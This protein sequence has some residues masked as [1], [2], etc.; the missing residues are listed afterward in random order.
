MAAITLRRLATAPARSRCASFF[1]VRTTS[2]HTSDETCAPTSLQRFEGNLSWGRACDDSVADWKCTGFLSGRGP[3]GNECVWTAVGTTGACGG[4]ILSRSFAAK[5]KKPKSKTED[6]VEVE[7]VSAAAKESAL[8]LMEMSLDV[9][10]RELSKLRTG[11]ASPGMLD[12]ITVEAH[13]VRTPLSHIAAVSVAGLR[14]LN[15]L[16]YDPSMLKEVE[17]ALL[18]SPLGLN[19]MVEGSTLT[20]PLPRGF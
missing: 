10:A 16:P 18:M 1:P 7:D 12:H 2:F 14:T 3:L 17:K 19:P 4:L 13:G 5:A 8:K 15:V 11:R 20:V 9:L 6:T